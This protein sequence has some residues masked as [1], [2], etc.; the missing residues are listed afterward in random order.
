MSS[1]CARI[2]F[3]RASIESPSPAPSTIVVFSLVILTRLAVP[4]CS[5]VAPS[6][7]KPTSSEITVPPVRIAISSSIA[8]L[9]SPKPGALQAETLTIPLRL[10]TTN[11]AK[12][13]P[14][15]SSAIISRGFPALATA[16]S[17]G[18]NSRMLEI[19]LSA[20]RI[21]GL[22]WSVLILSWLFM[23]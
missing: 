22:S 13:S 2:C 23:K 10:L 19:F 18:S 9:R 11:V 5:I 21:R 8:F 7:S 20:R 14:S 4:R 17:S 6:R 1:I 12:A 15:T 3:T 16:S